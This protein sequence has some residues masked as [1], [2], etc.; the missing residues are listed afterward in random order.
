M[1]NGKNIV[2]GEIDTDDEWI[3]APID[4]F[5]KAVL[6]S[7]RDSF[8]VKTNNPQLVETIEVLCGE[9]NI[10][11]YIYIDGKYYKEEDV[12]AI[13]NYLG[14]VYDILN[15]LRMER[16]LNEDI[17]DEIILQEIAEYELKH[18]YFDEETY[19]FDEE[20]F[21]LYIE[22][23][24]EPKHI[25]A[26]QTNEPV[27]YEDRYHKKVVAQSGDWIIKY[28]DGEITHRSSLG[29]YKEIEND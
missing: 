14:D 10:N 28:P 26:Y 12:Y 6:L 4:V 2:C 22:I 17:S 24:R 11:F 20:K 15:V 23:L 25:E 9:D 18:Q 19:S 5:K 3:G 21:K 13:Y 16:D 1:C 27:V 29:Q 8:C 7:K